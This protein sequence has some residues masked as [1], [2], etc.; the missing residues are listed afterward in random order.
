[1]IP[2]GC[3]SPEAFVNLEVELSEDFPT[4]ATV[5]WDAAEEEEATAR[6]AWRRDDAD[7]ERYVEATRT[8]DRWE[9]VVVGL[10][11]ETTY[12]LVATVDSDDG[13]QQSEPQ[14]LTTGPLPASF[15]RFTMDGEQAAA[16]RGGFLLT[17]FVSIPSAAVIIDLQR[18]D[19]VW[20]Y[21]EEHEDT[22]IRRAHLAREAT[23]IYMLESD[24]LYYSEAQRESDLVWMVLDGSD[25]SRAPIKGLHHDFVE[26][27]DGVIAII[28]KDQ[29]LVQE[30]PNVAVAGDQI[31]ELVAGGDNDVVWSLWD[32]PAYAPG[33]IDQVLDGESHANALDH[34]PDSD[35]YYLS[36]R[37]LQA[38]FAVDRASGET[39]WQFGGDRSD[40]TSPDGDT[41]LTTLQHQFQVLDDTLLVFD[42]GNEYQAGSR[43]VE[44][45]LDHDSGIA[46]VIWEYRKDP[47]D[48]CYALGDVTRFD[49]GNTMITWSTSGIIEEVDPQG[50]VV[51]RMTLPLGVGLGYTTWFETLNP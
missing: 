35:T 50:E 22:S 38:I 17:T 31:V 51:W 13:L 41:H 23:A 14:A 15:T 27:P 33:M 3:A 20:W 49:D 24:S 2:A 7:D 6:V 44:Y 18:G 25:V 48:L 5:R 28:H 36:S 21:V 8:G 16:D 40:F 43:V 1:V 19:Y 45:G 34:D 46:E 37:N 39:L 30:D 10:L 4:V 47:T 11:P 26:R 9:A 12:S 42:N 29:R 32:T